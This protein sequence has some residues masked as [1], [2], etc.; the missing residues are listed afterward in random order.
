MCTH[1]KRASAQV[2]THGWKLISRF[3]YPQ[4]YKNAR[5]YTDPQN[6]ESAEFGE[7][8]NVYIA[9]PERPDERPQSFRVRVRTKTN[10]SNNAYTDCQTM[11]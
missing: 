10:W 4:L 11:D 3:P 1:V 5:V 7:V 9:L 6:V 2:I 8:W